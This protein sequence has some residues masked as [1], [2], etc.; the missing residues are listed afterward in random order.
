MHKK[1]KKNKLQILYNVDILAN[2]E[3]KFAG[4]SG[5]FFVVLNVLKELLK[6]KRVEVTL[7]C[8]LLHYK[9]I[10]KFKNTHISD[11]VK[12]IVTDVPKFVAENFPYNN[13][14]I[15]AVA[16]VEKK[17]KI[18][19]TNMF[20]H[21]LKKL[22]FYFVFYPVKK[23]IYYM[24]IPN[25]IFQIKDFDVYFSS[26]YRIPNWAK[27]N[28]NMKKY[29]ILYDAIP[30]LFS[31][32]SCE[33]I[34]TGGWYKELVKSFSKQYYYFSIS[35]NTKRDF[36]RLHGDRLDFEKIHVTHLAC[37][38]SFKPADA[39]KINTIKQKY[40]IPTDKKYIFSLCTLEPRK[41]LVRAV[42][43]FIDFIRKNNI[44][45]LVF[46]LG[47]GHWEDF[48]GII[49]NSISELDNF[50]EK[51]IKI[52]YV[53]DE[54]LAPLYSGA[55]WFVYTSMYEGFG[56]PPLE[57]MSCGC[58]VITSNNSSLPEVVGDA[59]IMINYD[60]D[61]EHINAYEEYYYNQS[62]REQNKINGF[63][64]AKNFTW[65]KCVNSMIELILQNRND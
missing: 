50:Q 10:K 43:T 49:S 45:D 21:I 17:D 52:G 56:L 57:A 31:E 4:R 8:S 38:D 61:A 39:E 18:Q 9:S 20:K 58:P 27:F 25:L 1:I 46:V 48:I 2:W 54:D 32:Y 28:K 6:D 7:L 44:D 40:N 42:K 59:G 63:N 29:T 34:K 62:L 55:E 14:I 19:Y 16:G 37:D 24:N 3:S 15:T 65:D 47:G 22:L 53:D 35:E 33:K 26:C 13:K 5:I 11:D 41:N 60:S 30:E 23:I 36:F 12:I 64:R 51:I